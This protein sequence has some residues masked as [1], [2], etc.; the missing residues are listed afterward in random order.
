MNHVKSA[1]YVLYECDCICLLLLV[2]MHVMLVAVSECMYCQLM[3]IQEDRDKLKYFSRLVKDSVTSV[4][5]DH[6]I[7]I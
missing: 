4:S 7:T 2:I 1:C 3:I 6:L 5:N